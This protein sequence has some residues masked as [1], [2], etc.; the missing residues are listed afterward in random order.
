VGLTEDLPRQ[1][2]VWWAEYEHRRRPVLVVS[3]SDAV[4]RLERLVVAPVTS[5]VR[6]IPT[7]IALGSAEGVPRDCAAS[8]D[9]STL[10]HVSLLTSRVGHLAFA[11]NRICTAL[12]A[13]AN[14]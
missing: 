11:K 3:R 5:T 1:G 6:R 13:L 10:Q 14:C 7:E 12:E 2:E 9:N 4:G 8:F